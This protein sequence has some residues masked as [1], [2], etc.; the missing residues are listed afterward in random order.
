MQWSAEIAMLD[1]WHG[2]D[3]NQQ[4]GKVQRFFRDHL[5]KAYDAGKKGCS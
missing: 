4:T 1:M 5:Q 3:L 2:M